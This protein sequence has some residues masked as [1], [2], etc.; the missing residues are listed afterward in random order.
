MTLRKPKELP[1]FDDVDR[2]QQDAHAPHKHL[3]LI[4]GE[5][6]KDQAMHAVLDHTEPSYKSLLEGAL[7]SFPAGRRITVEDL[8]RVVG[9]PPA[10][11]HFNAVGAIVNAMA[12]RGLI[13][14]TGRMIKAERPGMH[15]T[16]LAEWEVVKF[17]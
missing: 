8:T 5:E 10:G 4:T 3:R 12:R 15:A 17:A 1:L 6:L 7:L 2:L 9:R 14:K 13:R 11:T 16:E